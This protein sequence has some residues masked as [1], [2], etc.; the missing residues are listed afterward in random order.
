MGLKELT[1]FESCALFNQLCS[2]IKD[3]EKDLYFPGASPNK[4][5]KYLKSKE[6]GTSLGMMDIEKLEGYQKLCKN[7]ELKEKNYELE[8]SRMKDEVKKKDTE[9]KRVD[10]E[11]TEVTSK[12]AL[13]S[14]EVVDL[15]Q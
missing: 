13:K 5:V 10:K 15:L 12:A 7:M 1:K 14:T 9:K 4:E 2:E 11:L 8:I 6:V 3:S